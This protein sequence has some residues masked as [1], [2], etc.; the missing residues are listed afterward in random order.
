MNRRA[1]LT[2]TNLWHAVRVAVSAIL[3]FAA[4]QKALQLA[5]EPGSPSASFLDLPIVN[6]FAVLFES[7]FAIWLLGGLFPKFTRIATALLFTFFAAVSL[8]KGLHGLDSCGCFGAKRVN[9]YV[10]FSLDAVIVLL[11]TFCAFTAGSS[12]SV[13]ESKPGRARLIATL[14]ASCAVSA[15]FGATVLYMLETRAPV[16]LLEQDQKIKRG[17]SVILDANLWIGKPFPLA[18]FCAE[19]K[20]LSTGRW[21]VMIHRI[22]CSECRRAF[23]IVLKAAKEEN[24]PLALVN[25]DPE[26]EVDAEG[27]VAL[28]DRLS[29]G[30]RWFAETPV[31]FTLDEGIVGEIRKY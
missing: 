25:I 18:P 3:L 20:R 28:N 24:L 22:D 30:Y 31:V 5:T 2:G 26:T 4:W 23:P 14:A 12:P 6:F 11:S 29:P 16:A 7:G 27:D 9:P 19:G 10:T 17:A 15:A 8:S 21:L 1:Y 13:S